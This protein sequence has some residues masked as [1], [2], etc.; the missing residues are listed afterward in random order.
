MIYSADKVI[1]VSKSIGEDY[2][3][4]YGIDEP[5][6]IMNCSV[7]QDYKGKDYFRKRFNIPKD[8]VIF[9]YVGIHKEGRGLE[10]LVE[11]F[12]EAS[13]EN[14]K[15]ITTKRKAFVFLS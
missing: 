4:I 15:I 12:R 2:M 6:L 11:L 9:L 14:K 7:L 8:N 13:K 1:V 5:Y 3:K 10:K